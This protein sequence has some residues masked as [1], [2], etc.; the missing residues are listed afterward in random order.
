[1]NE[2]SKGFG[3]IPI[4]TITELTLERKKKMPARTF[5][6]KMFPVYGT[7]KFKV[8]IGKFVIKD[9]LDAQR[10]D[11][12]MGP[13]KLDANI[14]FIAWCAN[15]IIRKADPYWDKSVSQL[16]NMFCDETFKEMT[17]LFQESNSGEV[18]KKLRELNKEM[19]S[20]LLGKI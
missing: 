6:Q 14:Y 16:L 4:V 13:D 8:P 1:M 7:E 2:Q 5:K 15:R 17:L 19:D 11:W 3:D 10:I 20:P 9:Q 12:K 18:K